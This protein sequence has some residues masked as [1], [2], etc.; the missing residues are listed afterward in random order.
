MQTGLSL[1]ETWTIQQHRG[2]FSYYCENLEIILIDVT[3]DDVCYAIRN[4]IL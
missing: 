1:L 2:L 3:E 4:V